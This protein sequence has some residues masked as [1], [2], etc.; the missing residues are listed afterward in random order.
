MLDTFEILTTSG[1]VLW[2]RS[3]APVGANVIN[4]LIR[5]VFIEERI[6]PQP[7]DAGAKPTYKKEGYTLKW[8]A[9]KDLGLIFVV[10]DYI[11]SSQD[12]LEHE[13][14]ALETRMRH[15]KIYLLIRHTGSLPEPGTPHVDRQAPRQ[16]TR[17]VRR[18]LRRAIKD[19]AQ[20]CRQL[21]QVRVVFRPPDARLGRRK[22]FRRPQHQDLDTA[23]EH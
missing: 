4:S 18:S 6:L 17:P 14:I 19:G 22:R 10:C 12:I 1:V 3:Y 16:C 13:R 23:L 11:I 5:D 20:Q 21:R 8:T 2:S 15:S 7:E 9:S